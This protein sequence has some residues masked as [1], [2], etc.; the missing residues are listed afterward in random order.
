MTQKHHLRS[1]LIRIAV[2]AIVVAAWEF[3][4]RLLDISP[5]V[6]PPFSDAMLTLW[7]RAV[8]G[9]LW[10]SLLASLSLLGK[11]VGIGI[12]I[13]IALTALAFIVPGGKD[14]LQTLVA[15]FNPLPAIA[16][17]PLAL[18]W[19]GFTERSIVLVIVFAVVWA[20][21]LNAYAGF[22]TIR[23]VLVDVGRNVGLSGP[24][25][26]G[27]IYFPAALPHILSG[28]RIGWAFAWR[29][30]V[31]AELVYGAAGGNGGIGWQIYLDRSLFNTSGVF[32]GLIT[33]IVVG[34]VVEYGI[35]T[36]IES[37]T[38]RRWG[39]VSES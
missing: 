32:A 23:T 9:S 21:A 20:M 14:V 7:E 12:I 33:I 13:A 17:L 37:K 38:V 34:L 28:L 11:G 26:V 3:A 27:K 19:F 25:L 2:V 29:T 16:V 30:A 6:L 39:M 4:P 22:A 10:V 18:L 8:D 31:A 36:T 5:L 15:L 1:L 24:A 35:F